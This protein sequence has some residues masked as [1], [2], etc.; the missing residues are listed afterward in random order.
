MPI[1][2]ITDVRRLPRLGKIRLG[3]KKKTADGVEYPTA[4][5]HF[6]FKDV[7]EVAAIYGGNCKEL[8]VVFPV[9]DTE[10]FFRQARIAYGLSRIF[11]RCDDMVT[12]TRMRVEA[13][14]D[15]DGEKF[16]KAQGLQVKEGER[17]ELP[18]VPED[19]PYAL[20]AKK[21]C[22]GIGRLM[23]MLP[24]VP[25]FGC[26]EVTT[27]SFHSMVSLNSYIDAVRNQAGRISMIPLKLKLVP[28][29]VAPGGKKKT[30]FTM[31]VIFEGSMEDLRAF[32]NNT[33]LAGPMPQAALP[34]HEE[35]DKEIP[36]DLVNTE[37]KALEAMIGSEQTFEDTPGDPDAAEKARK[38]LEDGDAQEPLEETPPPPPAR[39]APAQE[40]KKTAAK[41]PN[42]P[43]GRTF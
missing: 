10:L 11:C 7:P 2:G 18:C 33:L 8:D 27:T 35:L 34:T 42:K 39:P 9:E 41:T 26:Y 16:I 43:T 15:A 4:L 13:G 40:P 6:S 12:A 37:G 30:V 28:T 24:R 20:S 21:L 29:N 25:R 5:D 19:C 22:R 3:E 38:L 31:Q 32:G 23:F 14:K 36:T 1:K 17:Y